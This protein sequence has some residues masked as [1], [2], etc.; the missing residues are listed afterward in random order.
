MLAGCLHPEGSWPAYRRWQQHRCQCRRCAASLRFVAD[1]IGSEDQ[2]L[3]LFCSSCTHDKL[4]DGLL[5]PSACYKAQIRCDHFHS[6]SVLFNYFYDCAKHVPAMPCIS[7]GKAIGQP[8]VSHILYDCRSW[9]AAQLGMRR[10]CL[11]LVN[12]RCCIVSNPC[13]TSFFRKAGRQVVS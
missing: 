4:V 1:H 8:P 5:Q 12:C 13:C 9:P 11:M 3:T 6:A 2:V 7:A 10:S